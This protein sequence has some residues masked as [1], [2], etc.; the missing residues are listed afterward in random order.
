M[1]NTISEY[2]V[3]VN[4]L[5]VIQSCLKSIATS[6]EGAAERDLAVLRDPY[7]VARNGNEC[8]IDWDGSTHSGSTFD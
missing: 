2:K 6:Y 1:H 8:T 3:T 5:N 7:H 4:T